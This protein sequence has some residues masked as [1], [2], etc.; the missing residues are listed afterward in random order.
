MT[1]IKATCP[2]CGEVDLT[3][4]DILLRI[5]TGRPMNTYGFSCP[6]CGDFVEK[7]ADERVTRLLLSGGVLPTLFHV[8]AKV[9]ESRQGPPINHDDLLSFHELLKTD[10]WFDELIG[11]RRS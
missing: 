2:A 11:N 3:A 8:P 7:P 5:G 4:E 6:D 9:L 1:T 10:D